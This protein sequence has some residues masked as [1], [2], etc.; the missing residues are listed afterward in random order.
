MQKEGFDRSFLS[1]IAII[2]KIICGL[3]FYIKARTGTAVLQKHSFPWHPLPTKSTGLI[4][5][6]IMHTWVVTLY[7]E[8]Y[9]KQSYSYLQLETWIQH[10]DQIITTNYRTGMAINDIFFLQRPVAEFSKWDQFGCTHCLLSS[11]FVCRWL[12]GCQQCVMCE[13][14]H[15]WQHGHH[16]SD[17]ALVALNATSKEFML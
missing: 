1:C 15:I 11:V 4:S 7:Q 14:L 8:L 5:I 16:W 13:T 6:V 2:K 10:V 17:K 9:G 12:H 3:N